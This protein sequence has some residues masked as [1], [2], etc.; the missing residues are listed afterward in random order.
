MM[1]ER[2]LWQAEKSKRRSQTSRHVSNPFRN[3]RAKVLHS[4]TTSLSNLDED[5]QTGKA[6][7]EGVGR[8]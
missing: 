1:W 4:D 5:N 6:I 8:A 7:G 3:H 2:R